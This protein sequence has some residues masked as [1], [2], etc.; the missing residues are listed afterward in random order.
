M[1]CRGCRLATD[2]PPGGAAGH[3]LICADRAGKVRMALLAAL[4]DLD[5][6]AA[7]VIADVDLGRSGR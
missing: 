1:V 6:Q 4:P 7:D 3:R 5:L 2:L